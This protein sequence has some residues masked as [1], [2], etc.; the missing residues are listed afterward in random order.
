MSRLI[1]EGDTISR[2]GK[3][4]PTP[5]IEKLKIYQ[6]SFECT[7]SIYLHITENPERNEE[8]YEDLSNLKLF[9]G[10]GQTNPVP[11]ELNLGQDDYFALVN[12]NIYNSEGQRFAKFAFIRREAYQQDFQLNRAISDN[13]MRET[14]FSCFIAVSE[15]ERDVRNS[16]L[17]GLSTDDQTIREF[18]RRGNYNI[19]SNVAS[20]L[21]YEKVFTAPIGANRSAPNRIATD[22]RIIYEDSIGL[23][24]ESIPLQSVQKDYYKT[25]DS[26]RENLKK[27]IDDLVASYGEVEDQQLQSFLDSISYVSETQNRGV[28]FIIELDKVRNSFPSRTSTSPLGIL[29]NRLKTIIFSANDAIILGE[30]LQKKIVP[31]TKIVDLRDVFTRFSITEWS[32][33]DEESY[34]PRLDDTG[35]TLYNHVL[36]ERQQIE[37]PKIVELSTGESR[38]YDAGSGLREPDYDITSIF[39]YFFF[40]YEK[41]LHKKSNISQIYEIQKLLN[42]FGNNSLDRY[43][44]FQ[45]T[46]MRK[47]DNRRGEVR[48]I[49]TPY[50]NNRPVTH[51]MIPAN[52]TTPIQK[53]DYYE[54]EGQSNFTEIPYVTPRAFNT[55]DGL[56]DYRLLAFEF[57]DFEDARSSNRS[58]QSYRFNVYI[59]DNTLDFY[60]TLV[61]QFEQH[62]QS[63]KKY[64]DFANDFCSYNNI[65]NRFNDFFVKS[66]DEYFAL[67]GSKP[68]Q[69]MPKLYTIHFDLITNAFSGQQSSMSNYADEQSNLISPQNGTL[70]QLQNFVQTVEDFYENYY[71]QNGEIT[72]LISARRNAD[73][74]RSP[75]LKDNTSYI[76]TL[77]YDALPDV[78]D[79]TVDPSPPVKIKFW[80]GH[81]DFIN[82]PTARAFISYRAGTIALA[83]SKDDS[84]MQFVEEQGGYVPIEVLNEVFEPSRLAKILAGGAGAGAAATTGA[85]IGASSALTSGTAGALLAAGGTQAGTAVGVALGASATTSATVG[86]V[87]GTVSVTTQAAPAVAATGVVGL[88]VLIAALVAILVVVLVRRSRR[89]RIRRIIKFIDKFMSRLPTSGGS[90]SERKAAINAEINFALDVENDSRPQRYKD[91][92]DH[93]LEFIRENRS[94]FGNIGL[95]YIKSEKQGLINDTNRWFRKKTKNIRN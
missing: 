77:G 47:F 11:V 82:G 75:S 93:D 76:A 83:S 59:D 86:G 56:G 1:F 80:N 19:Y 63:L 92:T 23:P 44:E 54:P 43:F 5:F 3:K 69:V 51:L 18:D 7:I 84:V 68:W 20:P 73:G 87:V 65:D 10:F 53:V 36:M 14:Y 31:N 62:L 85:T 13:L 34:T 2:F 71:G 45:R 33:R 66:I 95:V 64:L 6:D 12:E 32:R 94:V 58:G 90:Y 25:T 55:V 78:V 46:E 48:R 15:D 38:L 74:V 4:I 81:E 57:Q 28:E 35:E 26:F 67:Q 42:I 61:E 89:M 24:Y 88:V 17:T 49:T 22:P 79:L 50:S 40:D 60:Q 41:A 30:S 52:E 21:V 72:R 8:I 27:Q 16:R 39:G 91:L 9:Y 70:E 29:Y 37:T